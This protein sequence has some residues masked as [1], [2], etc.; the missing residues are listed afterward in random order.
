MASPQN[1]PPPQ[2]ASPLAVGS[3]AA[4]QRLGISERLLWTLGRSG[5][6]PHVRIGKRK[7]FRVADLEAFLEARLARPS[8]RARA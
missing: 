1:G 2:A 3:K 4:A 7:L 5:E 8:R 6:L